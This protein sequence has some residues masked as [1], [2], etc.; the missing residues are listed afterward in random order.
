MFRDTCPSAWCINY[1][2]KHN[3]NSVPPEL[4]LLVQQYCGATNCSM[5]EYL[6]LTFVDRLHSAEL[7]FL[8][9]CHRLNDSYSRHDNMN[10]ISSQNI[11]ITVAHQLSRSPWLNNYS[12]NNISP[13]R[14]IK[15]VRIYIPTFWSFFF[16]FFKN[17][18]Y[19]TTLLPLTKLLL[20]CSD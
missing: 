3:R 14:G 18:I 7:F 12:K 9:V 16:F 11:I 15:Y 13:N 20:L 5:T 1:W 2:K 6:R 4:T 17:R 8:S 19:W 10:I